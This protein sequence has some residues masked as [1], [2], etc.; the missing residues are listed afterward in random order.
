MLLR[1][2]HNVERPYL[3]AFLLQRAGQQRVHCTNPV[4]VRMVLHLRLKGLH[5]TGQ[6]RLGL[7]E[8]DLRQKLIAVEHLAHMRTNS[9]GHLRQYADNFVAFVAFK[10]A[11]SVVGL[12]HFGRFDEHRTA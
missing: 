3:F 10:F 5:L 7:H 2:Q 9:F 12:H 8:V 11:Y 4:D 6:L 1:R